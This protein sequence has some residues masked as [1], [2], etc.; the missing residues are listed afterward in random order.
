MHRKGEG[1]NP[2][3]FLDCRLTLA[4]VSDLNPNLENQLKA[5]MLDCHPP[6]AGTIVSHQVKQISNEK[7]VFFDTISPD[8]ELNIGDFHYDQ[9]R[10]N[11]DFY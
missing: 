3:P 6:A 1:A 5:T 10:C 8:L 7:K 2:K 9:K 4:E 11:Q